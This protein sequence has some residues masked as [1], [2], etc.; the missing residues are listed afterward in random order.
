MRRTCAFKLSPGFTVAVEDGLGEIL[1]PLDVPCRVVYG[2]L[3]TSL[4]VG[5]AMALPRG[6]S[7]R[8]I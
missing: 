2:E 5:E 7:G 8:A 6:V 3:E 4:E 1:M